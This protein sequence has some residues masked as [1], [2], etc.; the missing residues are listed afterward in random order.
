[1]SNEIVKQF[2]ISVDGDHIGI[3]D[4]IGSNFDNGNWNKKF[5]VTVILREIEDA[6]N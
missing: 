5:E 6:D 4:W 3:V 2:L 1:M